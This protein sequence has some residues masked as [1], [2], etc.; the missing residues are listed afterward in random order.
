MSS[1]S[2]IFSPSAFVAVSPNHF[3]E[4]AFH[5]PHI[6][7]MDQQRHKPE[8]QLSRPAIFYPSPP[9]SHSPPSPTSGATFEPEPL[10]RHLGGLVAH[11]SRRLSS[12]RRE[13]DHMG[14]PPASRRR[15]E[16]HEES[17]HP[18]P[19]RNAVAGPGFRYGAG[20]DERG[21]FEQQQREPDSDFR[22]R[23]RSTVQLEP[24][25]ES[26][27]SMHLK[28]GRRA[29]NHVAS[30]CVNCKKAHLACDE[31]RPCQRCVTAGKEGSCVDIQHKKRGR[32]RLRDD[33]SSHPTTTA[34]A[35][36]AA[37]RPARLPSLSTHPALSNA[38]RYR[39]I[40]A[41]GRI[42]SAPNSPFDDVVRSDSDRTSLS[43][44]AQSWSP[45]YAASG[46]GM[47][48][49]YLHTDMVVAKASRAFHDHFALSAAELEGRSL[50]ELVDPVDR[51]K[52]YRVMGRLQQ[53]RQ[54]RDPNYLPPIYV[55]SE[56]DA[57]QAVSE[58][59]LRQITS[60]S[61]PIAEDLSFALPGNRSSRCA[62]DLRL[63]KTSVYFIVLAVSFIHEPVA[64][65]I[66]WTPPSR[67]TTS[68]SSRPST[69]LS[70]S[71]SHLW[72]TMRR[73][74]DLASLPS[75]ESSVESSRTVR[76]SPGQPSPGQ[77]HGSPRHHGS[78]SSTL[79]YLDEKLPPSMASVQLSTPFQE[80]RR[81]DGH[82]LVL[83]PIR[84][85]FRPSRNVHVETTDSAK[86]TGEGKHGNRQ[87]QRR[88]RVSVEE[89]LQ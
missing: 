32:P 71:R 66:A 75:S 33:R 63:A 15:I 13:S 16:Y 3:R 7:S 23:S 53:E 48:V 88:L 73:P 12:P 11:G 64:P 67:Y 81:G 21:G 89:M 85:A 41:E 2:Q 28:A 43:S 4:K 83:P 14:M 26:V 59:D 80:A 51:D 69:A 55:G 62:V 30:A 68:A 5:H 10:P 52:I 45:S 50:A 74:S 46:S 27:S 78:T 20:A 72:Q 35:S 38:T 24:Y 87:S 44:P 17:L 65:S 77:S 37:Q 47:M 29:K 8:S 56:A 54:S 57:I 76:H 36:R 34:Q 60:G 22:P 79:G 19:L 6:F 25:N 49:A 9:M 61:V 84:D 82:P 1:V 42:A 40:R 58:V 39:V 31:N 86:A 18:L 70:D